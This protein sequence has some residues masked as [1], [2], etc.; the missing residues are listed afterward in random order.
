MR[1]VEAEIDDGLRGVVEGVALVG[2]GL[3]RWF[4]RVGQAPPYAW[5]WVLL[6][7]RDVNRQA[8]EEV[9]VEFG[10][11]HVRERQQGLAH[12]FQV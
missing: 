5:F 3:R 2:H 11:V 7:W 9:A 12:V 1:F 10:G 8:L 4:F 6:C